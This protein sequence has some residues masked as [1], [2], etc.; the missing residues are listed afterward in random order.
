VTSR[1]SLGQLK[2]FFASAFALA[3]VLLQPCLAQSIRYRVAVLPFTVT[4]LTN[5][6]REPKKLGEVLPNYFDAP[7]SN[8]NKFELVDRSI[9]D[10]ITDEITL[11]ETGFIP[12][13]DAKKFGELYPVDIFINGNVIIEQQ[14]EQPYAINVKFTETSTGATKYA[15]LL[16]AKDSSEFELV[17]QQLI[18]EAVLAFPLR[19]QVYSIENEVVYIDLGSSGGLTSQDKTGLIFRTVPIKEKQI[20]TQIGTFTITQVDDDLSIITPITNEGYSVQEGDSVEI[21][22]LD[23]ATTPTTPAQQDSPSTETQSQ[24]A[25]ATSAEPVSP[26][27][28]LDIQPLMPGQEETF[29]ELAQK[30]GVVRLGAG[31]FVLETF[32]RLPNSV[33]IIGAGKDLT[34]LQGHGR[35]VVLHLGSGAGSFK[36]SNLTVEYQ[37]TNSSDVIWV[38]A[39]D[40]EI[41]DVVIQGGHSVGGDSHGDGLYIFGTTRGHL[42]GIGYG[43]EASPKIGTNHFENNDSGDTGLVE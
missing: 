22:S 19:S 4:D 43:Q 41:H 30:G 18:S 29:I 10:K 6:V 21:V 36:L 27:D 39:Q 24:P 5:E 32:L 20:K 35:Q 14:G 3:F 15:K 38:N 42:Y 25:S 17:A 28:E 1:P 26:T 13:E 7:I 2:L 16:R 31:T 11:S 37:G 12:A 40:V 34:L 33:E 23:T 8:S 9:L